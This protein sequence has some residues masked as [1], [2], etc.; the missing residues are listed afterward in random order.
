MCLAQTRGSGKGTVHGIHCPSEAGVSFVSTRSGRRSLAGVGGG[1]YT[2]VV[3]R[4][5]DFPVHG[6]TSTHRLSCE[7]GQASLGLPAF[8]TKILRFQEAQRLPRPPA[9]QG[10]R[11]TSA[12]VWESPNTKLGHLSRVSGAH[13]SD[14]WS[15]GGD[16]EGGQGAK[17]GSLRES[18]RRPQPNRDLAQIPHASP[19]R[20]QVMGAEASR[21]GP[22]PRP[23]LTAASSLTWEI[24]FKRHEC[25]AMHMKGM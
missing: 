5:P 12:W 9:G 10:W 23:Q 11:K 4:A 21:E 7:Q 15:Q 1:A 20:K 22:P 18:W 14:S 19:A 24:S 17:R 16:Q 25:R 3:T 8:Q 2:I 13:P 6:D